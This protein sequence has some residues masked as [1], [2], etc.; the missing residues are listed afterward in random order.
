M[1]GFIKKVIRNRFMLLMILP[2]TIWFLIF[3]YLPMFGTV[4]AFKDFRISPDGFFAS[5]FNSEWVGFKNFEYLFTTNDAYII[6]RNTIL[7]NLAFIILGLVI[8][9]GFAIMLSELVNKRTA[10]VY[11]T[12]MFLPHF[13]SWVIIS[14]FAFTF[15]SVDKGTL[16]QIIT[17]FGGEPISWYS[18]AKYWPFIIIFVGIWKGV[19]YNS[20]IYLAAITGIDKSYYEAAVIDGASKWKQ[21][22]YITIPLLKPLMIILTILAIGGIFRSDFGLFYQ[23][24]KDSGALYPVT[25]VIDTFVYR[26]LINMGDIGM[27]TAAGLY[28]SFVG[29]VLILVANYIVRKIEKDHAIF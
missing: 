2:G 7:Y 4:L 12:G 8:A 29:L 20:V 6:T 16:N 28:Q 26:G 15:L 27:S 14:Y 23:L 3:A 5:V 24:P 17:Y 22:R 25:N 1:S 9:V 13:L 21:V 11:Q 19:G 18:E 10:K